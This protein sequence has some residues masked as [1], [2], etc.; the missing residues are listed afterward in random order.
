[1]QF[2]QSVP[3]AEVLATEGN[4]QVG[5]KFY[6]HIHV[7]SVLLSSAD[8][9]YNFSFWSCLDRA[10]SGNMHQVKKGRMASAQRWWTRTSRA[11]VSHFKRFHAYSLPAEDPRGVILLL[12]CP[13]SWLLCHHIH[14]GSRRQTPG[15][16]AA[17]KDRW[18]K[19]APPP[20]VFSFILQKMTWSMDTLFVNSYCQVTLESSPLFIQGNSSTSTLATSWVETPNLCRRPWSWVKRWWRGWEAC[21][22]SSTRSSGSS[23]TRPSCTSG[24]RR[25]HTQK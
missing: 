1:M 23:A 2:V 17:D 5:R 24:G 15:Q 18:G 12:L 16:P 13:S 19:H 22:A 3:V 6:I 10:S 4:I 25:P 14:P 8:K 9:L 11:V 21:R 7:H 20:T